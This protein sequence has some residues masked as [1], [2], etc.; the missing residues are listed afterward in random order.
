MKELVLEVGNQVTTIVE[1]RL[2]SD[3]YL[4]FKRELGWRPENY[5]WAIRANVEKVRAECLRKRY[6]KEALQSC[7]DRAKE[8]D[9]YKTD[10]C[11]NEYHC[12]C[13]YKKGGLH[14][15]TGLLGYARNFFKKWNIPYRLVDKRPAVPPKT[16]NY[17]LSE[18]F[19]ERPYQRE[20]RE[21]M[22]FTKRGL[23]KIATGGGKTAIGASVIADVGV[24]PSI[25]Y[26]TSIDL[27]KQGY[28][29]LTSFLRRNGSTA[30]VGMVGGGK[31]DIKD[32]TVMTVQTAMTALDQKVEKYDDEDD[33]AEDDTDI[34]DIKADIKDLIRSSKL[35]MCDEVQ[36]W[37]S[38]TCQTIADASREAYYRYG[39]SATPYRD[40]GDDLLIDACFGRPIVD[41][42][43]SYLIR[44]NY[45]IKPEILFLHVNNMRD[46]EYSSYAKVY[47]H[48]LKE[49]TLRNEW[50]VKI[51]T[52]MYEKGR[53]P[54]ILCK[55][56]DHGRL[57][58]A[59]M[60]D[61][62]K[63]VSGIVSGKKRKKHL[64]LM[65]SGQGGI[66]IATSIFDEGVD[67]KRLDCLIQAGSG[68]SA[69][70]ALQ[71]IGRILRPFP[72]IENNIKKSVVAVDF[73]D[74]VKYLDEHS[75]KR[76]QIYETEEEFVIKDVTL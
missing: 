57:L 55:H 32:V 1:G 22:V 44:K 29:D 14:F 33:S 75:Q 37:A 61:T 16:I 42:S 41:I 6:S 21:K 10:V 73:V 24:S 8:W 52:R 25:F 74:N 19:E 30:E 71:R 36:H 28:D 23:A 67:V 5:L 40:M 49:N 2:E 17:S 70:R 54:L 72:D 48:C 58:Q 39:L 43:A 62:S 35:M 20:A 26:V 69:S 51:A 65:R 4:L 34:S 64:D 45:L 53:V 60:P 59:M 31:K 11:Y 38:K 18:K 7:I 13:Y 50:I 15:S 46:T 56:L 27:L 3:A 66:T 47:Q 68:K 9:G 76:R 63:F 12:H